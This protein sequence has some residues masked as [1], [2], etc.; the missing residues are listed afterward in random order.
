M[1]DK[2]TISRYWNSPKIYYE[3]TNEKIQLQMD[4]SDFIT[5]LKQE[6]GSVTTT[7]TQKGFETKLDNAVST[8]LKRVKEESA[9]VVS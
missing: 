4:L 9:K 2:F 1:D 3:L 6:I 5:A 7:I 8:V